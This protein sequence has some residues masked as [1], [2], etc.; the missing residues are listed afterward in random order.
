LGCGGG[1]R[2]HLLS[3]ILA[4]RRQKQAV[5]KP[6]VQGQPELHL[7]S[8]ATQRN[9]VSTKQNKTN[10]NPGPTTTK[11]KP[12]TKLNKQGKKSTNEGGGFHFRQSSGLQNCLSVLLIM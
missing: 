2:W 3:L 6:R 8:R 4:L 7:N 12:Q 5:T 9:L 1:S 11:T 10:K